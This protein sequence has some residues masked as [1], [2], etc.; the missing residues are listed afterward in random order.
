MLQDHMTRKYQ[1]FDFKKKLIF[2]IKRN[3]IYAHLKGT[4]NKLK[5]TSL[6]LFDAGQIQESAVGAL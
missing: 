6:W 2:G 1:I 4:E 5:H 3:Q